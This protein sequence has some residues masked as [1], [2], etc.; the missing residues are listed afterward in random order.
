MVSLKDH[1]IGMLGVSVYAAIL[2]LQNRSHFSVQTV[3]P[4]IVY[5]TLLKYLTIGRQRM[6]GDELAVSRRTR[7]GGEVQD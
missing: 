3:S 2:K 6:I 1:K 7:D 5:F 4:Y